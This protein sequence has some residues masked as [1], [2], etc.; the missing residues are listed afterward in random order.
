[1]STA[2]AILSCC[3]LLMLTNLALAKEWHGI[4][5]L[6]S[7]RADVEKR[8]GPAKEPSKR[9]VSRHET[10]DEEVTVEYSTGLP[11]GTGWPGIWRIPPGTVVTINVH[12]KRE[13]RFAHLKINES[14][15]TKT[16]NQGHGPSYFYYTDEK[17]GIQY[18]VTQGLVMAIRYLPASS[19]NHLR[20][21]AGNSTGSLS[22]YS[23]SNEWRGIVP[24]HSTRADVEKLLG[25]AKP[26][27]QTGMLDYETEN[28]E[29]TVMYAS[30]PPCANN[31]F[32]IWKVPRDT[33]GRNNHPSKERTAFR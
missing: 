31:G 24:L 21:P 28:E 13:L 20:C 5:P 7:T 10:Q 30:G 9:H 29:V 15:F 18:E 2:K 6:H 12:P 23:N 26:S 33:V 22:S 17:E 27:T 11:C 19:D 25:S 3:C 32:R 1:M 16:D 4:T 8:L 14:Q